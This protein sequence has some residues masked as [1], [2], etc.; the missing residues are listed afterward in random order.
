[1]EKEFIKLLTKE[2]SRSECV[3]KAYS[4]DEEMIE[5]FL[6]GEVTMPISRVVKL[7]SKLKG[8]NTLPSTHQVNDKVELSLLTDNIKSCKIIKVHFTESKVQYDIELYIES[9]DGKL[10][11][12]TRVY[13]IDSCFVNKKV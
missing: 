6:S 3:G 10:G 8:T 13:N 12:S 9:E 4:T 1:M 11:Y 5:H 7:V 2:F